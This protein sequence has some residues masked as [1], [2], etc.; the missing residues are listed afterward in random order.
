MSIR[1]SETSPCKTS[2]T[3]VFH[4]F[5]AD[6]GP[7]YGQEVDLLASY[8]VLDNLTLFAKFAAYFADDHPVV[9]G[10]STDVQRGWLYAEYKF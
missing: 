6:A 9:Q 3:T 5:S 1:E 8:P 4:D 7:H 2:L 10:R